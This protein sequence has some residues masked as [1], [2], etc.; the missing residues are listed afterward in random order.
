[1][2]RLFY[3]SLFLALFSLIVAS[4]A[5]ASRVR[6][7]DPSTEGNPASCPPNDRCCVC[8]AEAVQ[9]YNNCVSTNCDTFPVNLTGWTR[10]LCQMQ[11]DSVKNQDILKCTTDGLCQESQ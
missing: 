7:Q 11:C 3:R 5:L 2:K 10:L 6:N 9:R 1:M 8:K 4:P